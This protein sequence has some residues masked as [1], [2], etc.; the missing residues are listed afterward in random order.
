MPAHRPIRG[1]PM[2]PGAARTRRA[3]ANIK[4]DTDRAAERGGRGDSG[5]ANSNVGARPRRV[6]TAPR[7]AAYGAPTVLV[8]D[9]GET[10][11]SL[12]EAYLADIDCHLVM[13][14]DGPSALG[15]I[16]EQM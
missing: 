7:R 12:V 10:N 5:G 4:V 3:G 9:D 8:V 13:A 1:R 2:R 14:H 6:L 15:A 11:R 16:K